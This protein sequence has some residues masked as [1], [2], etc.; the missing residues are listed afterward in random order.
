[1]ARPLVTM[2]LVGA[3]ELERNLRALPKR[4]QR[5]TLER[6]LLRAGEP[7]ELAAKARAAAV[8][9]TGKNASKIDVLKTLSRR[10]RPG[11]RKAHPGERIVYIGVRPSPVAHLIEFGTGPRYTKGKGKK[12]KVV[13]A[14]RG[15]MKPQ[16]FMRPAWEAKKGEA[17][18]TLG[19]ILGEEIEKTAARLARRDARGTRGRYR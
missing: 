11:A 14:Y 9:A 12:R 18:D 8:G 15:A 13:G 17:L 19:R 2:R 4:L 1:M 5:G 7:V 16:P 3:R 6:A 10:Q